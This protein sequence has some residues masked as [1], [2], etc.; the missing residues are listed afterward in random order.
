MKVS[1]SELQLIKKPFKFK[2]YPNGHS[3]N[4]RDSLSVFDSVMIVKIAA[5]LFFCHPFAISIKEHL[6]LALVVHWLHH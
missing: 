4:Y 2:S 1:D 3:P 5:M 6:L